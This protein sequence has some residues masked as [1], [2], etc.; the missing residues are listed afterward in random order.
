MAE[1]EQIYDVSVSL[2][3]SV[4]SGTRRRAGI[5]VGRDEGY[6]GPLTKE[7]LK[8]INADPALTVKK[9]GEASE[10][11]TSVAQAA[12][13]V[14][15]AEAEAAKILDEAKAEAERITSDAKAKGEEAVNAANAQAQKIVEDAK[16]S[17]QQKS[18]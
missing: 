14:A 10:E 8:A 12:Q 16:S 9:A 18:K 5:V 7:Q 15:D 2:P 3:S 11:D 6:T 13:V 1:Q 4:S 17:E